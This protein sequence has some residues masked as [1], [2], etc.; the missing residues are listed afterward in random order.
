MSNGTV[1]RHSV[2]R[3][4]EIEERVAFSSFNKEMIEVQRL[5]RPSMLDERLSRTDRLFN[6][7]V[8]GQR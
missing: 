3:K 6:R 1:M 4:V 7:V 5:L 8:Y 2:A